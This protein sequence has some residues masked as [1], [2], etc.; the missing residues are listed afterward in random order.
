MNTKKLTK[1]LRKFLLSGKLDEQ[2]F[3]NM[4]S[5]I[6]HVKNFNTE[7]KKLFS[8]LSEEKIDA[9]T[10]GRLRQV[11]EKS[12]RDRLKNFSFSVKT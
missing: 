5:R 3:S 12:F 10:N 1:I 6:N 9:D 8:L 4:K 11:L 2:N 7:S